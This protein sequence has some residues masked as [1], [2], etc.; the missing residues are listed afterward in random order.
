MV[1]LAFPLGHG[2]ERNTYKPCPERFSWNGEDTRAQ[3]SRTVWGEGFSDVD[4][5]RLVLHL[6]HFSD[7]P[8][9][10]LHANLMPALLSSDVVVWFIPAGNTTG[11]SDSFTITFYSRTIDS[12]H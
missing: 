10:L 9:G 4:A 6:R 1:L 12:S 7:A 3:L 2:P 8:L 5:H 11:S